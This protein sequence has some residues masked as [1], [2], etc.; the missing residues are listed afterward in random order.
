MVERMM[1]VS[2]L[3]N[4]INSYSWETFFTLL[5]IL[6]IT[7]L[8]LLFNIAPP[9]LPSFYCTF[10]L[11]CLT[12]F[13]SLHSTTF[14]STLFSIFLS[15]LSYSSF[16]FFPIS[17]T[18]RRCTKMWSADEIRMCD[19]SSKMFLRWLRGE[20]IQGS[21]SHFARLKDLK[22]EEGRG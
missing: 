7:L 6:F 15:S 16:L 18:H 14:L 12:Y 8:I 10:L 17:A 22:S 1:R 11:L 21:S 20:H 3:R 9:P 19:K 5:I 2:L 4:K 13:F